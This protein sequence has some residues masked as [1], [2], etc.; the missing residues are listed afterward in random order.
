[1]RTNFTPTIVHETTAFGGRIIAVELETPRAGGDWDSAAAASV[2]TDPTRSRRVPANSRPVA[3]S[4]RPILTGPVTS[5][6]STKGL[7]S[8]AD[9]AFAAAENRELGAT[10]DRNSIC[11]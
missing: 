5:P 11:G 8:V 9:A 7:R 3:V 10:D 6:P 4:S 2:R 1:M